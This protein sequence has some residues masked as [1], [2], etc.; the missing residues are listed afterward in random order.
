[1]LP[2]SH[3]RY[4]SYQELY[5]ITLSDTLHINISVTL[6]KNTKWKNLQLWETTLHQNQEFWTIQKQFSVAIL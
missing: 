5:F 3:K 4:I 6:Y 1:M 2:C